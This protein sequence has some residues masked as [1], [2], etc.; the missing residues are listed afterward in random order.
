MQTEEIPPRKEDILLGR[1]RG[2]K[3]GYGYSQ[4]QFIGV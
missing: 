4:T 2:I 3:N 1:D